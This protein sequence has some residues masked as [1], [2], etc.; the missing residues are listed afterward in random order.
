MH[1]F[2]GGGS[3][4][5]A[6]RCGGWLTRA[7]SLPNADD[8]TLSIKAFQEATGTKQLRWI[9]GASHIDLYGRP[10]YVD[11]TIEKIAEFFT[12]VLRNQKTPVA[13]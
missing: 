10:Q 1:L 7:L 9:E 11:P 8:S 5:F 6:R 4:Q 13:A 3:W 2:A 12:N